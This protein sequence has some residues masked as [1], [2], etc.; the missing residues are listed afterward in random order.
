M[1]IV[2]GTFP[3]LVDVLVRFFCFLGIS[4]GIK[5]QSLHN[6]R[7]FCCFI[8]QLSMQIMFIRCIRTNQTFSLQIKVKYIKA[9]LR[10]F[11]QGQ[12]ISVQCAKVN[13]E[14]KREIIF[15]F[16]TADNICVY[17]FILSRTSQIKDKFCFQLNTQ[18]Q[19]QQHYFVLIIDSDY[20]DGSHCQPIYVYLNKLGKTVSTVE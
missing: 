2:F 14:G 19:Q 10:S 9:F 8:E 12:F 11:K 1:S 5:F 16:D 4:V 17:L 7:T 3:R 20:K 18:D 6:D 15:T 13:F